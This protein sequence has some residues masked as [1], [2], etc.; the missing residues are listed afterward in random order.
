[1]KILHAPVNIANCGTLLAK[2]QKLLGADAEVHTRDK[3]HIQYPIDREIGFSTGTRAERV[4]RAF[5]YF[6]DV[7]SQG[8]D[9][10][11][12][13]YRATLLP[14]GYGIPDYLDLD[15]LRGLPN[16]KI[17]FHFVGCD[18]R[19]PEL[20]LAR[21]SSSMC[22]S[23]RQCNGESKIEPLQ[24]L[25]ERCNG[26]IIGGR[27]S[28][29]FLPGIRTNILP[30]PIEPDD[31]GT[32]GEQRRVPRI[33]HM[34]TNRKIKGTDAIIAAVKQL[35][36]G[37]IK[38]D[39]ELVEGVSHEQAKAKLR[40]CDILIDQTGSDFY[41]TTAVEAMAMGRVVLTGMLPEFR[42][43]YGDEAPVIPIGAGDIG[44]KLKWCIGDVGERARLASAGQEY[45]RQHH[46]YRKI[47]QQSL[48]IYTDSPK[49]VANPDEASR[50]F[51]QVRD[52]VVA[53]RAN[54]RQR[55]DTIESD[56]TASPPR[57][58]LLGRIFGG[59]Q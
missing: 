56:Q 2:G 36:R 53:N 4:E 26:I 37:G 9:V 52:S 50:I 58:T 7:L 5:R 1:M 46:D 13:Y 39:F 21:N 38:F 24:Y 55:Q 57:T 28:E 27:Q 15:I 6:A 49:P 10:F 3:G 41:A 11:H 59:G 31:L 16:K 40:N 47:A 14:R 20:S 44:E 17:F 43:Q 54:Y 12:F 48:N 33:I 25:V 30:L 29:L 42:C 51:Q 32:G 18:H 8:F 45:A 22:A 34:P 35:E 23:C 19:L